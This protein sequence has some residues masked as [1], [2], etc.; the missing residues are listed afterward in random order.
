MST[1]VPIK[2]ATTTC[3]PSVTVKVTSSTAKPPANVAI[4][5]DGSIKDAF[6]RDGSKTSDG[7][8]SSSGPPPSSMKQ[9][10][11]RVGEE[12]MTHR[13]VNASFG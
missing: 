6:N 7:D 5:V 8:S 1:T 3:G 13:L 2:T 12:C 11:L 9:S 4:M 10:S